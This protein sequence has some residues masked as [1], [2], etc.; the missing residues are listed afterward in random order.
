MLDQ[1]LYDT[2]RDVVSLCRSNDYSDRRKLLLFRD[3]KPEIL[4]K[5]IHTLISNLANSGLNSRQVSDEELQVT[6]FENDS[7]NLDL[8]ILAA[9]NPEIA[10]ELKK[11]TPQEGKNRFD[12]Y[13]NSIKEKAREDVHSY[14]TTRRTVLNSI[15]KRFFNF[16]YKDMRRLKKKYDSDFK[17]IYESYIERASKQEIKEY[18]ERKFGYNLH[19]TCDEIRMTYQFDESCQGTVP[20]SIIAFLESTDYESAIRLAVSLGGDAD[21]MGAITGGIAEAFYGGVPEHIRNEVVKRL[22]AEFIDIMQQFYER[23]IER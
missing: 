9:L 1:S 15:G 8:I 23:F 18:V 2:R 13:Q 16:S 10:G 22:P 21:T 7:G 5:R 3:K 14:F 20:E 4:H 6:N 11:I 19:R 17:T 12:E